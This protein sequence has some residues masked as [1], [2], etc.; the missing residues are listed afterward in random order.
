MLLL[1]V[2]WFALVYDNPTV[3]PWISDAEKKYIMSNGGS[4]L[5]TAEKVQVVINV[6]VL[7]NIRS[8]FLRYRV[9]S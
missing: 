4:I 1:A 2:C 6:H 9:R 8:I 7:F 3:H 5:S